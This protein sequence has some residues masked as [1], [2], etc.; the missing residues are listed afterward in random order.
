M[1]VKLISK[2]T[3][4]IRP[5]EQDSHPTQVTQLSS[6]S[7]PCLTVRM[8]VEQN[9]HPNLVT[10]LSYNSHPRLAVCMSVEQNSRPNLVTQL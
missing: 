3:S 2:T 4:C 9:S 5:I 7:H 6:N 1:V 10:Q 8:T